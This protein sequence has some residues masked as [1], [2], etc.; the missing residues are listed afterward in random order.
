MLRKTGGAVP[1]FEGSQ[2]RIH[3]KQV[4]HGPDIIW[5]SGGGGLA[6]DWDTYQLPYFRD[7]FR[8]TTFDNRGVGTTECSLPLPW[9]LEAF[10]LDTAELIRAVCVPPVA[11]VGLSFGAGIVQ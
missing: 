5:V 10:A 8:N 1:S 6:S 9:Q 11:L 3:Y 7:A 4:G 2:A